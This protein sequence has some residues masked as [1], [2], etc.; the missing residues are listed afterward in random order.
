MRFGIGE[1]VRSNARYCARKGEWCLL[2]IKKATT[3]RDGL[4]KIAG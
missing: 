4:T 2:G 1:D 3:K